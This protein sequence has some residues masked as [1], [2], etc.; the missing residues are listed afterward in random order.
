MIIHAACPLLVPLRKPGYQVAV[1]NPQGARNQRL[2][3]T[4]EM[5]LPFVNPLDS[6]LLPPPSLYTDRSFP[7]G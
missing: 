2:F 4:K 6:V 7:S 3:P 1:V 5:M